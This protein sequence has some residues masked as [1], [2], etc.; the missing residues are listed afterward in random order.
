MTTFSR[1][2]TGA[3][4]SGAQ[5]PQPEWA[6]MTFPAGPAGE[7]VLPYR[8]IEAKAET[9][10]TGVQEGTDTEH[11]GGV[12]NSATQEH[13]LSPSASRA[14]TRA[15]SIT[16]VV[17]TNTPTVQFDPAPRFEPDSNPRGMPS[18]G[19][20]NIVRRSNALP[21]RG[22]NSTADKADAEEAGHILTGQSDPY[23][24]VSQFC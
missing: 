8:T 13:G 22:E 16:E 5:T 4:G 7:M 2:I 11:G 21:S 3:F 18:V 14:R 20:G 24:H 19:A 10:S 17:R 23:H 9:S 1:T 15:S 12:S 6:N